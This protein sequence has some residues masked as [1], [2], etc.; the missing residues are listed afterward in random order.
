MYW[1]IPHRLEKGTSVSEDVG[2]QREVDCEISHWLRG[3]QNI[4]Y[5]GVE[6]SP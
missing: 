2:P 5:K 6:T 4:I 3:E 1:G